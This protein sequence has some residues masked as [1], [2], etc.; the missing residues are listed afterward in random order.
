MPKARK[1]YVSGESGDCDIP[2]TT[3]DVRRSLDC[4]D[5]SHLTFKN[6]SILYF[7][8]YSKEDKKARPDL[9]N[10]DA[11]RICEEEDL[12][13]NDDYIAGDAIFVDMTADE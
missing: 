12:L 3:D 4:R 8:T 7:P 13:D 9:F 10:H 2:K 11:T 5:Y 6:Q 1:I